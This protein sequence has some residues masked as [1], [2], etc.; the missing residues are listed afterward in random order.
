MQSSTLQKI[1][2]NTEF[3]TVNQEAAQTY[4]TLCLVSIWIQLISVLTSVLH[5]ISLTVD[6]VVAV[7]WSL[8]Y[9]VYITEKL[10]FRQCSM[11]L[12]STIVITAPPVFGWNAWM[13]GK[14]C[15]PTDIF[16]KPFLYLIEIIFFL[17][18]LILGIL[19]VLLGRIAFMKS[20]VHPLGNM[21]GEEIAQKNNGNF[22]I[23]KML[24]MVIGTNYITWIP[25]LTL[26][27]V[28]IF[29]NSQS[30]MSAEAHIMYEYAR[31]IPLLN[32]V[33]NP[34]IYA[35]KDAKFRMAYRKL[36]HCIG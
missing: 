14:N 9:L 36:F 24:L 23:T 18:M 33:A 10:M 8:H 6:R 16:P 26:T 3:G 35:W 2:I 13:P 27:A 12:V 30:P 22:K 17:I 20:K 5:I 25:T 7:L 32:A 11:I 29:S 34:C 31:L 1:F 4:Q 19:N 15:F 21:Q 28:I